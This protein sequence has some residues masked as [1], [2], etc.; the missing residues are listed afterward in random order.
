LGM[1]AHA[2]FPFKYWALSSLNL[3]RPRACCHCLG[4][5]S[6]VWMFSWCPPSPLA[7]TTSAGF[8]QIQGKGFGAN[9]PFRTECYRIS[10]YFS[11]SNFRFTAKVSYRNFPVHPL[12]PQ[13]H[14]SSSTVLTHL[15]IIF[16][17]H[18]LSIFHFDT[19]VFIFQK[20]V[21]NSML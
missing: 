8:P 12:F 14:S 15:K 10:I 5:F 19:H 1:R 7:L 17:K 16:M 13:T 4:E 20:S 11:K 9:I 3:C 18:K 6:C 21:T 2:Y